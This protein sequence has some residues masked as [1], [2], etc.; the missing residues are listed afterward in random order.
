VCAMRITCVG[1]GPAGLYFAILTKL[2]DP[3][4]EV[5]VLE[6]NPEGVTYG[7]GITFSDDVI[8]GLHASDPV[9]AAEIRRTPGVWRDQTVFLAGRR[10]H[11]GGY[12][13][14]IGR[15]ELLEILAKRARELG[16]DIRYRH[17]VT[18]L[19]EF[20][21]ADL[22]LAA[23]GHNSRI[24]QLHA[25]A[26]G[27][28]AF[29]TRTTAARN[30]Y[31]WLGT[32][33][34]FPEFRYVFERT[35]AGWIWFS[36]YPYRASAEPGCANTTLIVEC[37]PE[38]WRGLG[39]DTLDPQQC[40]VALEGIFARYLH[41]QPLRVEC[42]RDQAAPWS[43]H[44]W[45]SNASWAHRNV[46]LAGDAAHTTHHSIGNGTLLAIDD[47]VELD[48]QLRVQ[49]YPQAAFNAYQ[50]SR[51]RAVATRQR[52]ARY[53]ARWF[54]QLDRWADLDPLRFSYALRTRIQ[55]IPSPPS[56]PTPPP[57]SGMPWLLH[58][59]TQHPVGRRARGWFSSPERRHR[60]RHTRS[61]DPGATC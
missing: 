10:A 27:G 2:R 51:M 22:V 24:R 42:R 17:Q 13:F 8:D 36:A 55:P 32:D 23:D 29:G 38:T 15:H 30:T 4:S 14:A 25:Q 5:T 57:P 28:S 7:W 6:R 46:V 31:I 40:L 9:T 53:S 37:R 33:A 34:L 41:G 20:A 18:D 50:L 11:L 35:A 19:D 52:L 61:P 44:T 58:R 60:A 39:F 49:P 21:D 12:G 1:A 45:V 48:R 26:H 16:V 3:D 47:V 54:E 43:T 56:R 59:A